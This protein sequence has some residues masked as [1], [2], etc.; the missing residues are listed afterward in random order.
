MKELSTGEVV[1][2]ESMT[3][4]IKEALEGLDPM[5]LI[6]EIRSDARTFFRGLLLTI[7][8]MGFGRVRVISTVR[9]LREQ[10][11]IYGCGRSIAECRAAGVPGEFSSP[12]VGV[13]TWCLPEDSKH[14][15]RMA[16]D[17]DLSGYPN[18][19][20]ELLGHVARSFKCTW[21]GAWKVKDYGHFEL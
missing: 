5:G 19:A 1:N 13:R 2:V 15:K 11:A 17:I 16:M 7:G 8:M 10:Q 18:S 9:T 4:R 6:E 3:P 20:L 12:K 21:G 14:V